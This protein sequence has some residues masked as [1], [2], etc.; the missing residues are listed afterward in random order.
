MEAVK[1]GAEFRKDSAMTDIIVA[2]NTGLRKFSCEDHSFLLIC[3][4]V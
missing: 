2:G 4:D 3:T 1:G